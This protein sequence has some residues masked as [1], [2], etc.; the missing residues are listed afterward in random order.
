ME[1]Y[2]YLTYKTGFNDGF[3]AQYQ[4]V[5]ILYVKNLI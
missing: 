5:Y 2:Y 3:R 1:Y 4:Q